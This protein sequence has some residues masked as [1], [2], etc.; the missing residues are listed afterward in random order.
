[1][2]KPEKI[3]IGDLLVQQ[4][5]ISSEQ[6]RVTLDEQ[7]R[8]GRKLGKLLVESGFV[9]EDQISEALAR[10][11]GVSFINLKYFNIPPDVARRLPET[12]AR[13]YRAI[14]LEDRKT[15][16][17]VGMSDPTDLFAFDEIARLL[18]RDID[19][20]VVNESMLLQAIDRVYRR[21]EEISGLAKE[22]EQDLGDTFVDFGALTANITL[23][24]APVVRLLQTL[25]EDASQVKASDIHIEPQEKRVQIRFRID[26]EL[27]LQTEA[28]LR[29]GPALVLRLKIMAG[30]DISEKRLPQ[31][32]RFNVKIRDQQMD[33][34]MSTMP[35]Q[36][37]ESVV[38]RLLNQS[39][40]VLG[41]D[42]L[43][44][45]PEMLQRLREL[46]T[47]SSGMVLV[48]G[49]TGSGKTT[50]LYA[51]LSEV[52]RVDKKIITVEDPVEYRLAG[53]NQVQVNE[54]IDLSFARV[55]RAAL[56]QDPDVIL[57]G[58]MRDEETAQIGLRAAITGHLV[59]STLH[60]RD[61]ASTPIRLI[62]MGAPSY[63]VATSLNAVIA[64]RLV[65]LV[66]ES[67]MEPYSP[68]PQ[69]QSWIRGGDFK[70]E[71]TPR[72]MKGKGCSHCNG[73]GFSGRRGVYELLE[74]SEELVAAVSEADPAAF[75]RA[76]RAKLAGQTLRS[77]GLRLALLGKTTVGEAMRV[78]SQAED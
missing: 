5:L 73:T 40:A 37:G 62:D 60:T 38:M 22:L 71:E 36:Y 32:G 51:A 18:K 19:L 11:L 1:M 53:I 16:Y 33:V 29:I 23:E 2:G 65:R 58:E 17:L 4:R 10:Q 64:Q 12:Q 52:N 42:R 15:D 77:N 21:T 20:A 55:L 70:P 76:A 45:P 47:R 14:V 68:T 61:A 72:L 69:E 54:K 3:R 66:C 43:G 44:V 34:R 30:L 39:S 48:T 41:L 31:D 74:M 57:V 46:L 9:T 8:T 67:C 26:G 27:I 56:R 63:M 7:R 75:I 25:F 78:T 49:P 35:V 59:F 24:E 28:D 6:L 13:R 50:T